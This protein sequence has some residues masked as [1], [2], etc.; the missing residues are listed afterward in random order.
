LGEMGLLADVTDDLTKLCR[1]I[2]CHVLALITKLPGK[3]YRL[4][5]DTGAPVRP[6][7]LH[8]FFAAG[9][10]ALE[11]DQVRL[12]ALEHK[13]KRALDAVVALRHLVSNQRKF[14]L[15][16]AEVRAKAW[17]TMRVQ[18]PGFC[19]RTLREPDVA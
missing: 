4:Q 1:Y 19:E 11:F 13:R 14:G 15:L 5:L 9:G 16:P 6:G 12:A 10:L 18:V 2:G 17:N 8:R 7:A 3:L